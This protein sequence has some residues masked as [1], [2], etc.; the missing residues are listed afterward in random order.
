MIFCQLL[1]IHKLGVSAAL[2]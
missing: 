2:S 1:A